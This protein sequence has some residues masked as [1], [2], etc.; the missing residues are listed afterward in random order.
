MAKQDSHFRLSLPS[1][2]WLQELADQYRVS[3]AR[4]LDAILRR[5]P[6]PDEFYLR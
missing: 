5:K 3:K 6:K 1:S 4:V 2:D